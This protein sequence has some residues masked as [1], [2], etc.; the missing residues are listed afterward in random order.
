MIAQARTKEEY[1]EALDAFDEAKPIIGRHVI[2]DLTIDIGHRAWTVTDDQ[3][4]LKRGNARKAIR[5]RIG[6]K[7]AVREYVKLHCL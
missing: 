7:N 6:V 3:Y 4:Y 5:L 1:M 2:G